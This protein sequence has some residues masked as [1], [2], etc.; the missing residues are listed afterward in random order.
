MLGGA[1]QINESLKVSKWFLRGLNKKLTYKISDFSP[2][3][4]DEWP[5]LDQY[6]KSDIGLETRFKKKYL[7][8]NWSEGAGKA[9]F[10]ISRVEWVKMG[11]QGYNGSPTFFEESEE[12]IGGHDHN[13]V[14]YLIK[15]KI[16]QK[17]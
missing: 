9:L 6:T 8:I 7:Y 12:N 11:H 16:L 14:L 15:T 4:I 13:S 17:N 3:E 1:I 10:Q 2:F 5:R